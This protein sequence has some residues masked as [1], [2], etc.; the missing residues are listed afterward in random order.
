MRESLAIGVEESLNELLERRIEG[1]EGWREG[2]IS[3][4]S[5]KT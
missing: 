3:A 2:T 1:R 5:W 4:T